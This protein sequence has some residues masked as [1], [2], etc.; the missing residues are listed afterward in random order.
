MGAPELM[1]VGGRAFTFMNLAKLID[2]DAFDGDSDPVSSPHPS[3]D[4][5]QSRERCAVTG[6]PNHCYEGSAS[7]EVIEPS[8]CSKRVSREDWERESGR[9]NIISRNNARSDDK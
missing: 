3:V 6:S 7:G 2:C 4:R 5:H 8:E 9:T 1:G